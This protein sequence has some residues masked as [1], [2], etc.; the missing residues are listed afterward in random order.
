[1]NNLNRIF[2]AITL[3]TLA[4]GATATQ[5]HGFSLPSANFVAVHRDTM[6]SN[7]FKGAEVNG[8]TVSAS[9]ENG[10]TTLKL[11]KDFKI[12][13]SPAPHFQVIDADGNTFLLRRLTIVGNKTHR[14]V[15]LP[16]Y[17]KSVAKVQ[18]WCAFAEVVL[19]EA[20]FESPVM[21]NAN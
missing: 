11:S 20:S 16:S 21:A 8:G 12:P 4:L 7:P 13:A 5:A 19:G 3:S 10:K 17:I 18:I 15:V 14:D 9:T 6:T 1:M 2:V